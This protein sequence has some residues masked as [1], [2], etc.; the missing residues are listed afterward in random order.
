[1][2]ATVD[3]RETLKA[4][5][6]KCPKHLLN[7]PELSWL[8]KWAKNS[9]MSSEILMTICHKNVWSRTTKKKKNLKF[10]LKIK[11]FSFLG[12]VSFLQLVHSGC[13][14][15]QVRKHL[16]APASSQR[17]HSPACCE[18]QTPRFSGLG[19]QCFCRSCCLLASFTKMRCSDANLMGSSCDCSEGTCTTK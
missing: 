18:A 13:G 5:D 17:W 15:V 9:K 14:P 7:V 10:F 3:L 6:K 11:I 1:M 8:K 4:P 16:R 12:T 19:S 2:I